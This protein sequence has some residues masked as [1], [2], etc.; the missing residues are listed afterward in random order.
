MKPG[1]KNLFVSL[2]VSSTFICLFFARHVFLNH[3][4]TQTHST[5]HALLVSKKCVGGC[6][7]TLFADLNPIGLVLYFS[8]IVHCIRTTTQIGMH[9]VGNNVLLNSILWLDCEKNNVMLSR[10]VFWL[11]KSSPN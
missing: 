9:C 1:S 8:C 11:S 6:K 7:V 2:F 3:H 4:I 5:L 10:H